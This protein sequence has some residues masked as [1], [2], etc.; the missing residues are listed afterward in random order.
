MN[1]SGRY[2]LICMRFDFYKGVNLWVLSGVWETRLFLSLPSPCMEPDCPSLEVMKP[3]YQTRPLHPL[4]VGN[5]RVVGRRCGAK[6]HRSVLGKPLSETWR[7]SLEEFQCEN[8]PLSRQRGR[9]F[10][11]SYSVLLTRA[12]LF[13]TRWPWE[14]SGLQLGQD[15]TCS[16]SSRLNKPVICAPLQTNT[17]QLDTCM[18]NRFSLWRA[19]KCDFITRLSR[20]SVF[21]FQRCAE[22]GQDSKGSICQTGRRPRGVGS[23][24]L[25]STSKIF[26]FLP[27]NLLTPP[28]RGAGRRGCTA[29]KCR[30]FKTSILW[31]NACRPS[32]RRPK[33]YRFCVIWWHSKDAFGH[34]WLGWLQKLIRCRC[35][36][37]CWQF[38]YCPTTGSGEIVLTGRQTH[39]QD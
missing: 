25:P 37:S 11:A 28:Q 2:A 1:V 29:D 36:S 33:Y 34:F 9:M 38:H 17:P 39:R 8:S 22:W 15:E 18:C 35:A 30:L 26:F 31:R 12:G 27:I 14:P 21:I 6:G 32:P 4:P 16:Q 3:L 20:Q 19:E 24:C 5:M 13:S 7:L 23:S 10:R